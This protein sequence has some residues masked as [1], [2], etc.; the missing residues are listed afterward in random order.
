MSSRA[1][2]AAASLY[3]PRALRASKRS[4]CARASCRHVALAEVVDCAR[5]L[6][7]WVVRELS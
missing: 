4:S 3:S 2:A 5:V 6:A 7:A 1:F